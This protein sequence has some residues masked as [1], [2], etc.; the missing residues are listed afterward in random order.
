MTTSLPTKAGSVIKL[1]EG[2]QPK[3][4]LLVA[5]LANVAS[6]LA[7]EEVWI[8]AGIDGT[9]GADSLHYA[10]R[11]IDIRIHNL[12]PAQAD[13]LVAG[14]IRHLGEANVDCFIEA[15]GTPN[16]HI[17]LEYDPHA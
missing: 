3:L 15:K 8:T 14:L 16:A 11:A 12:T 10:L 6:E 9:H 7:L 5:A 4:I 17:H 1:K 13:A 2:V